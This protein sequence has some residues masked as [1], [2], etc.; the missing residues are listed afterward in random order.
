M[1]KPKK[2]VFPRVANEVN[3][4]YDRLVIVCILSVL[5]TAKVPWEPNTFGRSC[6]DPKT[7]TVG[8]FA[9]IFLNR[10]YDSIE[11]YF[12]SHTFA[13]QQLYVEQL[14]GHS[15]IARGMAK[16]PTSYIRLITRLV[17]FQMRRRGMD[18][19]MDSSG[20]S[21]KTGSKWF[22]IRITRKSEK[23]DHIK[24]H[25]VIDVD[26]GIIMQ[27]TITDWKGADPAEFKRLIKRVLYGEKAKELRIPLWV[28]CR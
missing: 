17:I 9:K 8:V 2:R 19:A 20:F 15:V 1:G 11:A 28:N 7:V 14:P 22:D 27:Y 16:M 5:R 25:I 6:W 21:L 3:R 24:H 10:T 23:K 18:V 4:D 13:A 12:K 26:T